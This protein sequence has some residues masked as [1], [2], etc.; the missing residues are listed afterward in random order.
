MKSINSKITPTEII[1][2][3]RQIDK[4]HKGYISKDDFFRTF[5]SDI[6]EVHSIASFQIGIED[7]IKPLATKCKK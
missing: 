5:N 3:F 1:H 2:V 7:I 6:R 4:G